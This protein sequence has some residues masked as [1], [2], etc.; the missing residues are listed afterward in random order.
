MVIDF[1]THA[2]PDKLAPRAIASLV[3]GCGGIY[4]P[5]SD[6]TVSGLI[7]NMDDFGVDISVIQPVIT[8][9]SQL[10]KLNRCKAYLRANGVFDK[11]SF[12]EL[13]SENN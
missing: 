1:H 11:D 7:K 8:K 9:Q 10:E 6:G 4:P 2:F 12:V 5:C 13:T 3:E